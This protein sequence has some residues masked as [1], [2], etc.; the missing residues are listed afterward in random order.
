MFV[1][2]VFQDLAKKSPP[3]PH[4]KYFTVLLLS[5]LERS[6]FSVATLNASLLMFNSTSPKF[7]R[8][9]PCFWS[10][11]R[12]SAGWIL[13]RALITQPAVR[14]QLVIQIKA[15]M[16]KSQQLLLGY[17]SLETHS[18]AYIPCI[19][20]FSIMSLYRGPSWEKKNL[21]KYLK[22]NLCPTKMPVAELPAL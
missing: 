22:R 4:R 10:D 20:P 21:L 8:S 17:L 12:S 16:L 3:P 11:L 7:L 14:F 13:F 9:R 19:Y 15:Y 18:Q 1:Y 2:P 6:F 5:L